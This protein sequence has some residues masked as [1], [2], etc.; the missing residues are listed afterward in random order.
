MGGSGNWIKSL[1][2]NKKNIT[3][4]QVTLEKALFFTLDLSL[5]S[6]LSN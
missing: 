1:I 5:F 2:T 4:D 3:D 6:S